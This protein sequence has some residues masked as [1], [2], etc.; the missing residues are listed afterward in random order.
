[1]LFFL[2][3]Q[4]DRLAGPGVVLDVIVSDPDP[5]R[6]ADL[7]L[8]AGPDQLAALPVHIHDEAAAGAEAP[9]AAG[10]PGVGQGGQE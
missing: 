5:Q 10:R 6:A 9:D 4:L 7:R 3:R 2:Q 1:M 8:D